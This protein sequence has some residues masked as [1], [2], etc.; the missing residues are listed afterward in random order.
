MA[1][2]CLPRV[3]S[4]NETTTILPDT[5]ITNT[6]FKRGLDL[7]NGGSYTFIIKNIGDQSIKVNANLAV[8]PLAHLHI[9]REGL[10]CI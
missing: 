9:P 3:Q 2:N 1:F 4:T 8:D 6:P 10:G 7:G 5:K